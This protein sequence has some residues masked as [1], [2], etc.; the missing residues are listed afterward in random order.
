MCMFLLLVIGQG[1]KRFLQQPVHTNDFRDSKIVAPQSSVPMAGTLV[2]AARN[3]SNI[4]VWAELLGAASEISALTQPFMD[5]DISHFAAIFPGENSHQEHSPHV[6][7]HIS[8]ISEVSN[9]G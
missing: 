4:S 7:S 8:V 1:D 2:L 5:A 6:K 3:D 9:R